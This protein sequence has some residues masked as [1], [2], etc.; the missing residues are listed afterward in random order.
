MPGIEDEKLIEELNRVELTRRL[1]S[2]GALELSFLGVDESLEEVRTRDAETIGQLGVSYDELADAL[3]KVVKKALEMYSQPV[4][5][6][7]NILPPP[8]PNIPDFHH[9]ETIPHFDLANLPDINL[10]FLIGDLQVFLVVFMGWQDCPW[11]CSAHS[12]CNFMIINR[13]T[14][15]SV[16]GPELMPHLIRTHHFFGGPGS[17]Y[18]SDPK[19]LTNVLGLV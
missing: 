19:Q 11:G 17:P 10:G 14:G 5:P 12:R 13:N 7:P 3:D 15:Q 9:P 6:D 2:G 16:T 1:R 4:I 8:D 18:R